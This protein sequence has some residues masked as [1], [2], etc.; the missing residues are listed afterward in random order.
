MRIGALLRIEV[1]RAFKSRM[2]W[3]ML[4]LGIVITG[5]EFVI[6]P[7]RYSK[8]IIGTFD[9][10][11]G[12]TINTVFN[13]WFFSLQKNAIPL[14]QLYIMIMPLMAVF[15]YGYSAVSDLSFP[16]CFRKLSQMT[17]SYKSHRFPPRSFSA[18]LSAPIHRN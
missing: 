11:I 15:A 5:I 13:S 16:N 6:A 12:N 2:F 1:E 10:S 8:D 18:M 9:G 4:L 7:L 17:A 14:R 3:L